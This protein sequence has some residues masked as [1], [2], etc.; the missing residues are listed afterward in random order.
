[1]RP[2]RR[3]NSS[4]VAGRMA[5]S[6]WMWTSALGSV[7][8]SVGTRLSSMRPGRYHAGHDDGERARQPA[9]LAR[10]RRLRRDL[11]PRRLPSAHRERPLAPLHHLRQLPLPVRVSRPNADTIF[12][13]TIAVDGVARRLEASP[14]LQAHIWGTRHVEELSWLY[15]PAFAEDPSA[16]LEAA[17]AR[18]DR[19]VLG[20]I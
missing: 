10:R 8:R 12:S 3:E 20:P 17:S 7:A 2:A 13:G 1:L 11:V 9:S 18:L 5:P 16:R 6:R 15:C 4:S 14:G 19:K